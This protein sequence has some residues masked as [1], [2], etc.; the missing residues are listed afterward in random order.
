MHHPSPADLVLAALAEEREPAGE[1]VTRHLPDCASCRAEVAGLR[2]VIG[3]LRSG[4]AQQPADDCLDEI[5]I[6]RLL[7]SMAPERDQAALAHLASCARCR[8]QLAGAARLLRDPVVATELK[9]VALPPRR[10]D[11]RRTHIAI[12]GGLAA[13]A[14]A[15][16]LLWPEA[17]RL[18]DAETAGDDAAYRERTLTTT[19]APRIQGPL[20]SATLA[21]SLRWSSV[22][23]ADLYRVTFW[24]RD[25]E[26]AWSGETRDTVLALPAAL[27][28]SGLETLLWDVKARTGWDRWVSSDLVELTI[29]PPGRMPR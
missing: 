13:A 21:D 5:D 12:A 14:L 10:P 22:P 2:E 18:T 28:R 27:A 15:A 6:A 19:N 24:R 4:A 25:G 7:D 9:R 29:Y 1:F 17:A 26:V 8:A 16:V 3:A 23:A 11:R 20:G